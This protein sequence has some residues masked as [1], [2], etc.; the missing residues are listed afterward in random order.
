M[1]RVKYLEE[2]FLQKLDQPSEE[3]LYVSQ[4]TNDKQIVIT[5][6]Y[7]FA[8]FQNAFLVMVTLLTNCLILI[9]SEWKFFRKLHLSVKEESTKKIMPYLKKKK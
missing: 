9:T 7:S 8:G 2:K 6:E 1:S 3:V 5:A 4:E